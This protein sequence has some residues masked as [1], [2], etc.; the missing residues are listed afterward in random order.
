MDTLVEGFLKQSNDSGKKAQIVSLGAGSDTRFWRLSVRT[1]SPKATG[2]H[3]EA[4][5]HARV[6]GIPEGHIIHVH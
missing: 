4:D 6:D 1:V 5:L 3:Y 2:L